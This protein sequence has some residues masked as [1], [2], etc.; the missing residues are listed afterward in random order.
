MFDIDT[1]CNHAM[2][3]LCGFLNLNP[4]YNQNLMMKQ[5][6]AQQQQIQQNPF[7]SDEEDDDFNPFTS[8]LQDDEEDDE[9]NPF[10]TKE[11]EENPFFKSFQNNLI[12]R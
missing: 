8:G 11:D 1:N 3:M 12:R 4:V 6:Q 2:N 9:E 5:Q 10:I 7:L